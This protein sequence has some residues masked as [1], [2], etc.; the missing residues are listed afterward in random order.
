MRGFRATEAK[1]KMNFKLKE[2]FKMLNA[3]EPIGRL[4]HKQK[5][6]DVKRGY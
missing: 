6:Y 2:I 3:T 4:K 5:I 1:R